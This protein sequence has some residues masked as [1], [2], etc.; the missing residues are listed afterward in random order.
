MK[1]AIVLVVVGAMATTPALAQPPRPAGGGG[2]PSGSPPGHRGMPPPTDAML[3]PMLLRGANLTAEQ[4][5]RVR[6]ITS[7]R[8]AT[9]RSLLEQ[10][11]KAEDDLADRLFGGAA[12]SEV[13]AAVARISQLRDELLQ[14][15]TRAALE[16]RAVLSPEQ[17]A[18]AAY[19]KDRMRAL[20]AE[21]HDLTESG[22]K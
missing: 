17:L 14:E 5:A 21:M 8:Q 15:S 11:R 18:R 7:A 12:S 22:R 13:H 16:V 2:M 19:V 6:A 20:Q 10:L 3:L 9:L 4:H 1:I